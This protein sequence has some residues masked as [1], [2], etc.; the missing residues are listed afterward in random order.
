MLNLWQWLSEA[1]TSRTIHEIALRVNAS[2][3][4]RP[5]QDDLIYLN[6]SIDKLMKGDSRRV[7]DNGP[8][9]MS[10]RESGTFVYTRLLLIIIALIGEPLRAHLAIAN[11]L[12]PHLR[13]VRW[14]LMRQRHSNLRMHRQYNCHPAHLSAFATSISTQLPI[15]QSSRGRYSSR[16][17]L[18]PLR[19]H[20]SDRWRA[21][22]HHG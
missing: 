16:V 21:Q 2:T 4:K 19:H 10:M 18:R 12:S 7:D 22:Y 3:G 8:T 6:K 9:F 1:L 13:L 11:P 15:A 20:Q 5:N 17:V 14:N